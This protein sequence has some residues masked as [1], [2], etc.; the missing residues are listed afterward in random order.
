[1]SAPI[2]TPNVELPKPAE[3]MTQEEIVAAGNAIRNAA[4][5][6]PQQ[7]ADDVP[8]AAPGTGAPAPPAAP[9]APATAIPEGFSEFEVKPDGTVHTK[10]VTG[11]VFDG[12]VVEAFQKL[13]AS[14]VTTN[15]SYLNT[16]TLLEDIQQRVNAGSSP[17]AAATAAAVANPEAAATLATM[18]PE[19]FSNLYY[20]SLNDPGKATAMALAR[21]LGFDD[22]EEMKSTLT[23]MRVTHELSQAQIQSQQIQQQAPD[24]PIGDEKKLGIL[25]DVME[26]QGLISVDKNGMV[27]GDT[28][29]KVLMTHTYCVAKGLYEPS[30]PQQQSTTATSRPTPPPMTPRQSVVGGTPDIS[31]MTT[32]QIAAMAAQIR[33]GG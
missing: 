27:H 8:T 2:V 19:Q 17:E 15:Q 12:P 3:Q 23:N 11:E 33:H 10:L 25:Y 31:K 13:G 32:E 5:Q 29:E 9:D 28:P 16:K 21:E 24:F 26:K 7:A 6:Q 4:A 20:E 30:T 1:M 18:S 22:V 14:K